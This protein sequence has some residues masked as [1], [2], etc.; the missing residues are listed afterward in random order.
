MYLPAVESY[1]EGIFFEFD[2]FMLNKWIDENT[3]ESRIKIVQQELFN[4]ITNNAL[5]KAQKT[6]INQNIAESKAKIQQAWQNISQGWKQLTIN[7]G[8]LEVNDK[9]ALTNELRLRFDKEI[10]DVSQSTQMT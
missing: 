7:Q 4:M 9:N 2:N 10:K 6:G 8:N 5:M 3:K 1:G